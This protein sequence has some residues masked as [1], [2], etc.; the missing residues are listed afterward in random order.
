LE[1]QSSTTGLE[2]ALRLHDRATDLV[3]VF[4]LGAV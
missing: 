3:K 4:L 2:V 1:Q